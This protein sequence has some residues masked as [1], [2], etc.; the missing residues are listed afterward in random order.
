MGQ[1]HKVSRSLQHLLSRSL[2]H[3]LSRSLYHLLSRSLQHLLSRSAN[4]MYVILRSLGSGTVSIVLFDN[5]EVHCYSEV[6]RETQRSTH[7]ADHRVQTMWPVH[8]FPG[9]CPKH[10]TRMKGWESRGRTGGGAALTTRSTG[11]ASALPKTSCCCL[12]LRS[13]RHSRGMMLVPSRLLVPLTSREFIHSFR[14]F[15]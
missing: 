3:M 8:M 12:Q 13:A 14:L 6:K 1:F 15:L 10:P 5:A 2:Q 9:K 4:P 7:W 11:A